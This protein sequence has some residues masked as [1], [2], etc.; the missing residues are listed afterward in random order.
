MNVQKYTVEIDDGN[1]WWFKYGTEILHRENGPAVEHEDGYKAWYQNSEIHRLDGPA[2]E[3]PDGTKYWYQYGKEH[4]LDGPA[5]EFANGDKEWWIEGK[6]YNEAE[7]N[8]YIGKNTTY[9]G[10]EVIIDGKTYKLK[11]VDNS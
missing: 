3:Y 11:F 7:F 6:K 5:K 2:Q 9:D 10:K 1:T 8:A 4:R